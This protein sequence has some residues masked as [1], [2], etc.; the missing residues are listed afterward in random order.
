MSQTLSVNLSDA[1]IRRHI[2]DPS[3]RQLKD[4]RYPLRLRFNA[5]RTRASWHVIKYASGG[6][7][8][9]KAGAWPDLSTKALLSRLPEIQAELAVNPHS[10]RVRVS[11][12][13]S[14]GDVLRWYQERTAKNARLSRTRKATIKSA[15][16]RHL[17]PL[18]GEQPIQT[19]NHATLDE[20]LI[21]PLQ[22][23]LALSTVRQVLA[24]LKQS[25]KQAHKLGMIETNPT[26][27]VRFGDFI[28]ARIAPRAGVFRVDQLTGLMER[29]TRTDNEPRVM[30]LLMLLH[31][32]R[33]G[34]TRM[35]R[36]RDVDIERATW[37][38]PEQ[39][40]KSR[41]EHRLPLT[42]MAVDLLTRYRDWQREHGYT[43]VYLFPSAGRYRG[44]PITSVT[45][46][47][48][49]QS[50]SDKRW[51]SHDLRKLARTSWADLGIDYM[52]GEL[53]LNH[54][55]SKLDRTYIHTYVERQAR[56][57]LERY[58]EWLL[59]Y[60]LNDALAET[61]PRPTRNRRAMRK[62]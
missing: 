19:L 4:P 62:R 53:L 18:L 39:H 9:R 41:R 46:C 50:V 54:A 36:W 37:T 56:E 29:L 33:L 12:W 55:L 16:H 5:D 14:V 44:S 51:S 30:I 47:N 17:L 40:T 10:A 21:W 28:D 25:F 20:A 49:V 48:W 22:A 24:V 27:A 15:I 32:T 31:G 6:T 23:R 34:E 42:D 38:L 13:E 58:H 52:V 11:T 43:G 35:A 8:W 60:G 3:I 59:D 2:N 57:A 1:V 45:A 7:R 61:M 26:G